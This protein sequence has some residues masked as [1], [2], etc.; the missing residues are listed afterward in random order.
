MLPF[1]VSEY[2]QR[3]ENTK[4]KMRDQGLEVF[5]VFD[6]ANMN[7]LTGYDG[8]SFYVPQLIIVALHEELPI[9]LGREQDAN[10]ARITT[11]LPEDNIVGYPD[12]YLHH[13][14]RHPLDYLAHILK[15]RQLDKREIGLDMDSYYFSPAGYECLR[16]NLPRATFID[17]NSLISRLRAVKSPQELTYMRQAGKILERVM[18]VAMDVVSPGARQ[19]DAVAE[20]TAAQIHGLPEYGGDYPAIQ[21]LLPT[22]KNSSTPH[23]TWTDQPFREGEE[24]ILELAACRHRYHAPL[25]RTMF[26]GQPRPDYEKLADTVIE[27]LDAALAAIKPGATCEEVE[28][29]WRDTV[30]KKGVVKHSRIGYSMG[31]NYPPDWGEHVMSLRPGDKS[32]IESNMTFHVIPGIWQHGQGIEISESLIV[33]EEGWEPLTHVPRQ[34]RIK[35]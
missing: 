9:W 12:H 30:A 33:T 16:R 8:W 14:D 15:L 21:P 28:F 20:I 19:C 34:L 1:D 25:A 11:F 31:L 22:G 17:V 6:P 5:L 32:V 23:L 24:V 7:Y 2:K 35:P 3:I 29:A 10:G 4:A 18:E 26:L 13:A 27:G